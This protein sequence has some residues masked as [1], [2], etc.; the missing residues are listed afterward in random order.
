MTQ[1]MNS[2]LDEKTPWYLLYSFKD[3]S[4]LLFPTTPFTL[5]FFLFLTYDKKLST[6][7]IPYIYPQL[8]TDVVFV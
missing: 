5:S 6:V 4:G 3:A 8:F 1:V 7:C 2:S